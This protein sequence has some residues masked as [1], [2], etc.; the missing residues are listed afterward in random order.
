MRSQCQAINERDYK[1]WDE[2]RKGCLY[3]FRGGYHDVKELA[4]FHHGINTV[5]NLLENEFPEPYKIFADCV[6]K[7]QTRNR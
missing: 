1:T 5:F 4:I 7:T 6:A 3:T 2:Y